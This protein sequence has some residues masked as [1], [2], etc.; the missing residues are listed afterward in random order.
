[1]RLYRNSFQYKVAT[2]RFTFPIAILISLSLW[3]GTFS[4]W[5]NIMALAM[6]AFVAYMLIEINTKYSL[7][8]TRASLVSSFFLLFYSALP[9][10]HIGTINCMVPLLFL[11]LLNT[12]FKSYES[13]EASVPIFHSFFCLGLITL[14]EPYFILLTPVMYLY[15]NYLRS[16]SARTFFA[17]LLGI[18]IPYWLFLGYAVYTHDCSLVWIALQQLIS[19]AP[20]D[21]S[22]LHLQQCVS[23]GVL[24]FIF[25]ISSL[26]MVYSSYK[27][28][29]Q[30][31]IMLHIIA[32]MEIIINVML[33]LQPQHFIS[34]FTIQM[35]LGAV[36]IGY[37]FSFSFTRYTRI[38]SIVIA[39]LWG[40]LCLFNLWM[41]FFSF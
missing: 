4:G 3:G 2:G 12:L 8:R 14:I 41:H 10:M 39:L 23:W 31:R 24:F 15:M 9:F 35:I 28:K 18:S 32:M 40:A 36:A 20:I 30:T 7:I 6:C 27:E 5:D 29:V 25:C 19:F 16:F 33:A 21:Y 22:V 38:L 37:F 34:L 1:M 26:Y 11:L 17:G 13:A